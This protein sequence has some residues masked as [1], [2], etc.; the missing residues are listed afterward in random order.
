MDDNVLLSEDEQSLLQHM[1]ELE[2][3]GGSEPVLLML[4]PDDERFEFAS[5]L[6]SKGYLTSRQSENIF[7][8]K[9]SNWQVAFTTLGRE[10][11]IALSKP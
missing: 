11:A 6:V 4:E 9:L 5:S 1:L 8:G 10:T 2:K 3:T 7:G